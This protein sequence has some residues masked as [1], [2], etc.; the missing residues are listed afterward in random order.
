MPE[1]TM[2]EAI[3]T[4]LGRA[5]EDDPKVVIFGEDVGIDGVV[6]ELG[7][8]LGVHHLLRQGPLRHVDPLRHEKHL[9]D[10]GP[11]VGRDRR[12]D[13]PTA[14]R[15]QPAVLHSPDD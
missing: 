13:G 3:R 14:D 12:R 9:V 10:V 4:A 6:G 15:P 8:R 7:R 5:M 2:V 1:L 11:A